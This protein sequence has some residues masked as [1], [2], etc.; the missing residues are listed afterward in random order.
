MITVTDKANGVSHYIFDDAV[1]LTPD[2]LGIDTTAG[3][4]IGHLNQ[5]TAG[6][7][8]NV[9]PPE[10][11]AAQKYSFNGKTWA[12]LETDP[13]AQPVEQEPA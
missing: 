8:K 7:Y 13:Y 10:D 3:F 12:L 6:I 11:W 9:T 4:R 5:E 1:V 2:E